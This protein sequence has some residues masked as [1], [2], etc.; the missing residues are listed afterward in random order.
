MSACSLTKLSI[1]ELGPLPT[2][3]SN[4]PNLQ[5]TIHPSGMT[6]ETDGAVAGMRAAGVDD[7][8]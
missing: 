7:V 5:F 8:T 4:D 2:N 3:D 6:A 1:Q